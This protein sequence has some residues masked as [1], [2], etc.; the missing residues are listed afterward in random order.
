VL[1]AMALQDVTQ[2]LAR[3]LLWLFDHEGKPTLQTSQSDLALMVGATRQSVN[4]QLKIWERSGVLT[5]HG[6]KITL[7]DRGALATHA[8]G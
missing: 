3:R 5:L 8:G 2:R 1:D 7:L 4:K 6:R